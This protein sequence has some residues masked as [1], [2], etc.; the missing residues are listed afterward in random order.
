MKG[1][2]RWV[3]TKTLEVPVYKAPDIVAACAA[4]HNACM[5]M[6]DIAPEELVEDDIGADDVEDSPEPPS[7]DPEAAQRRDHVSAKLSCPGPS[8][9]LEYHRV[10]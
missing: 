1:R 7:Q 8:G 6:G 5:R 4:M 10:V 9:D 2:S 3:F